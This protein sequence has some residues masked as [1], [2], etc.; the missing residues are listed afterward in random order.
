MSTPSRFPRLITRFFDTGGNQMPTRLDFY[1]QHLDEDASCYFIRN[2]KGEWVSYCDLPPQII[3]IPRYAVILLGGLINGGDSDDA[4]TFLGNCW[5]TW[6][7]GA[8]NIG[9]HD[10]ERHLPMPEHSIDNE[11]RVLD[12]NLVPPGVDPSSLTGQA[13][14]DYK[15]KL[16]LI[17]EVGLLNSPVGA[18]DELVYSRRVF[19][20][21]EERAR[22]EAL[23]AE[24]RKRHAKEEPRNATL[25]AH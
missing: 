23:I 8:D 4:A 17:R 22:V 21:A 25:C 18:R 2:F 11:A 19:F 20:E 12:I 16:W 24:T 10:P 6:A 7:Y 13:L 14:A 9:P 3:G 15:A 1:E 5:F